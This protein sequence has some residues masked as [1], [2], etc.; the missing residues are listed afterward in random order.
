MLEAVEEKHRLDQDAALATQKSAHNKVRTTRK[1]LS[2]LRRAARM[3]CRD[4]G[5]RLFG[6]GAVLPSRLLAY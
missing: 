1:L 2:D 5:R 6:D 4:T 3:P